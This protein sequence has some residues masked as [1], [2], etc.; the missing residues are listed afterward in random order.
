MVSATRSRI[1]ESR[2]LLGSQAGFGGIVAAPVFRAV[3]TEALRV[4]DVPK[5]LPEAEATPTLTAANE[6]AYDLADA[7]TR[8]DVPNVLEEGDEE[9]A[10]GKEPAT[11]SPALQSYKAK[12]KAEQ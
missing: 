4:L 8:P 5:D 7:D 3:A 12:Q 1:R 2:F 6:P 10:G 9:P 11:R